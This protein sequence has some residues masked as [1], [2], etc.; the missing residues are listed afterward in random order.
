MV[1]FFFFFLLI[2][3]GASEKSGEEGFGDKKGLGGV[4]YL[5]GER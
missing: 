5:N 3:A 2:G 4:V 1:F